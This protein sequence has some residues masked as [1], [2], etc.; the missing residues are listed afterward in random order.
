MTFEEV[1]P[2]TQVFPP[3]KKLKPA[4]IKEVEQKEISEYQKVVM[5]DNF[6]FRTLDL[7]KL[8]ELEVPTIINLIFN[9]FSTRN[10]SSI[11]LNYQKREKLRPSNFTQLMKIKEKSKV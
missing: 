2:R 10:F 6:K 7:N 4:E 3:K 1:G 5:T 9:F 11:R 8:K